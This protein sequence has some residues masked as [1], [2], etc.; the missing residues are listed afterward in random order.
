MPKRTGFVIIF[1]QCQYVGSAKFHKDITVPLKRKFEFF[2]STVA[3][4]LGFVEVRCLLLVI[5]L[6]VRELKK[7]FFHCANC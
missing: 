2:K 6:W 1:Y 3:I 5:H 4:S 7:L